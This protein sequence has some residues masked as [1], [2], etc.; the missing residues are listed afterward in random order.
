MRRVFGLI[1]MFCFSLTPD[2]ANACKCVSNNPQQAFS[3]AKVV[4]IGRMLGGTER[5]SDYEMGDGQIQRVSLEAG[6]VRFSVEEVFKG[7]I[8]KK[9]TIWI[10]SEKRTSCGPYGL[11]RGARFL[12]YAYARENDMTAL[13]SGACTRTTEVKNAK[14][15]LDFLRK[16]PPPGTGGNLRGG[17]WADLRNVGATPLPDLKVR[18]HSAG[19]KAITVRTDKVGEFEAKNLKAGKYRI[20]PELPANY[21]SRPKYREITVVDGETATVGFYAYIGGRVVGR[22][23]D[24]EGRG[25]NWAFLHLEAYGGPIYGHSRGGDAR[26]E[27]DGV[28][29]GKYLLYL[30]MKNPDYRKERYF[31]YPGTFN[32]EEAAVINVGLGEAVE[33]LQFVLPDESKVRTVEGQVV[34]EDGKPATDA[35]VFLLCSRSI[36]P[37]GFAF[38]VGQISTEADGQGRF[39]L[40]GFTNEIYWIE[41]SAFK[42]GSRKGELIETTSPSRKIVLSENLTNIRLVLSRTERDRC[43]K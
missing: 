23:I 5:L 24:K 3:K 9:A 31:Y 34:W 29:P 1:V 19:N 35:Q 10:D 6:A 33:G 32:R 8:G 16:P 20:E 7:K 2:V 40:E 37:E 38:D 39:R 15:D 25:F 41:A 12:V 17:V 18:I 21:M 27:V 4:F 22:L 28:P 43:E 36:N 42:K 14:D 30:K 13:Y 11:R 26:F